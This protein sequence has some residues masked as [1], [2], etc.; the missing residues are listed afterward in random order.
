MAENDDNQTQP[1]MEIIDLEWTGIRYADFLFLVVILLVFIVLLLVLCLSSI[2]A[3]RLIYRR[4]TKERVDEEKERQQRQERVWK[5]YEDKIKLELEKNKI[6][7]ATKFP[8]STP[9]TKVACSRTDNCIH[10]TAMSS[11]YS[12]SHENL[13]KLPRRKPAN[14]LKE[15]SSTP[16]RSPNI[17]SEPLSQ[18][19]NNPKSQQPTFDPNLCQTIYIPQPYPA[20]MPSTPYM[21]A[22]TVPQPQY[23]YPQPLQYPQQPPPPPPRP[24]SKSDKRKK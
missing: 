24:K 21:T 13:R 6:D 1:R 20:Y 11:Y 2:F 18:R 8:T 12:K 5:E 4:R 16:S 14:Y 23:Y 15:P 7:E 3:I 17:P 10:S 9:A 19:R 22:P